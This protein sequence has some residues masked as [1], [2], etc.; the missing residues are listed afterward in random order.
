MSD[1][2]PTPNQET[3]PVPPVVPPAPPVVPPAP[4]TVM[5]YSEAYERALPTAKALDTAEL[6]TI[7]IDV[8][9]AVT[10]AVGA[11]PKIIA[12]RDSIAKELPTFDLKH[13]DELQTYTLATGHAH[14]MYSAA[15]SP[16]EA[17][18]AL[19]E[20]GIALRDLM[21]SDA[22]A[23]SN[24]G[25]ISGDKLSEF[26][27]NVGYKNLAFDLLG[28]SVLLRNSWIAIASKTAV[29]ID[30]LD[31]AASIGEQL[32]AAVGAREQ[33]PAVIAD[34][35][36]QRQRTFTLFVNAYDQARRA[37]SYLR[38]DEGDVESI[39]PSLY[40][41][42]TTSRKKPEPQPEP[43]APVTPGTTTTP[44]VPPLPGTPHSP[45]PVGTTPASASPIAVGLPGSPSFV[46]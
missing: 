44:V 37:I 30:E 16:P 25:L 10:T 26:K 22:V 3:N 14:A 18:Q 32:V 24:R 17:I 33:A 41:G 42:R 35:A 38:W 19:N 7:N 43:P 6:I 31:Q 8:P 12:L 15:S 34:V 45:A 13:L 4:P 39:A 29:T 9:S 5:H 46:S 27:T 11:M 40:A 21:Y 2:S 23:L 20:Q 36:Q 1:V 28:L